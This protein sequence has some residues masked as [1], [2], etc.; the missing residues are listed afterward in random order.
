MGSF[1]KSAVV[2]LAVLL[3]GCAHVE[4]G[5]CP[6]SA[7]DVENIDAVVRGFYDA[8]SRDDLNGFARVTTSNFYSFDGGQR[9]AGNALAELV[10]D[11]HARGVQ[12][13]WTIG[14]IDTHSGCDMAWAAWENVG[15]VGTI[16]ELKPVRWLESAVLVKRD[17][18]WKIDF[19]HSARAATAS[20]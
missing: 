15:S 19:F 6:T 7:A 3:G 18:R 20:K 12:L 14:P 10:R 5:V 16:A 4:R 1:V 8:L 2:L 9:Y 13:N 11:T 17:G